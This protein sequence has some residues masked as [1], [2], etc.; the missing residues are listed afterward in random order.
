MNRDIVLLSA[1]LRRYANCQ[2]LDLKTP[3]E[4]QR[5]LLAIAGDKHRHVASIGDDSCNICG[6]DLRDEIHR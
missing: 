3:Q 1:A 6:R 4:I 5:E 2:P